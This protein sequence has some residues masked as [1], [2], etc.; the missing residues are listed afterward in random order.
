[1][2]LLF[3][4][5]IRTDL[6]NFLQRNMGTCFWKEIGVECMGCGMQRSII[7]LL[8]GEFIAAFFMYPPIYTLIVMF[9]FLA[10]HI[11]F[12]IKNGHKV[13]IGLFILNIFITLTNYLL[14][15]Y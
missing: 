4:L 11:K 12:S 2:T 6:I 14:K 7:L 10:I 5:G 9:I 13:L 15:F 8:E 3:I 1:M